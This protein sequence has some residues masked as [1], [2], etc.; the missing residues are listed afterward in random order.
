[1][2]VCGATQQREKK[3]RRRRL[4]PASQGNKSQ[5]MKTIEGGTAALLPLRPSCLSMVQATSFH[6]IRRKLLR[7]FR[8]SAGVEEFRRSSAPQEQMME[9]RDQP[10]P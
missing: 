8:L 2:A 7:I 1:M 5:V 10:P 4:R 6:A 3:A 9:I